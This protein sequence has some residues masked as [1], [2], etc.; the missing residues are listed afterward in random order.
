MAHSSGKYDDFET[1]RKRAVAL[2]RGGYSLRQIR[3]E[4]KIF[5]N[6]ILSQL[7]KGEPP[8]EWTKRPNAKD[9]LRAKARELR[10]QGWTYDQIEAELGCSRSS[11]SLWVRDLPKPEPRYTPEEQR[12]LMNEGLAHKRA[13]QDR[14]REA[15][16]QAAAAAVGKLS[17]RELFLLGVG[18]YWAEGGKDKPYDRRENVV[19]VNSDPGMIEVF[20]AWLDLLG[21]ARDRLRY[22]LMIHENADVAAAKEYWA[23]LV[24]ADRSAFN[25]TTLKKHNPKTARKNVGDSYRGCLAI[26][27][28]KGADLYRRIEGSWYGIVVSAREADQSNRT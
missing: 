14:E 21:I 27:V 8:P 10:L 20:L 16:K 15:T 12:A 13:A 24:G 17:D 4:L 2:R 19:F 6:V 23:N 1:L 9:D 3:D 7:V 5:N 11:V 26:K 28:L 25:K 18:L 22:T